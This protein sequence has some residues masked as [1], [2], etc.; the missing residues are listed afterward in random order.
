MLIA[1]TIIF[2]LLTLVIGGNRSAKGLITL[3]INS[4]FLLSVIFF[5]YKG[6]NPL[7]ISISACVFICLI[8]IFYQNGYNIKTKT[9]FIS[10]IIII[11]VLLPVIYFL[12]GLADI[13]GFTREQFEITDT[14][15]Y[16]RNIDVNM[17]LLQISVVIMLATGTII[18]TAMA[19]SS[20][21]HQVYENNPHL[22]KQQLFISGLNIGKDILGTTIQTIFFI[23]VA[24]YMNLL[25]Q[26][27]DG[28]SIS[29]IINSKAFVQE[30]VNI[31]S[32]CIGCTAIIPLT[33]LIASFSFVNL[34]SDICRQS[35][36]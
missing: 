36:D 33:A 35:T 26:F 27:M 22:S 14:N 21:L 11:A 9:A 18:D 28:Y 5:V 25:I 3:S 20:A 13:Q 24:E 12:G 16:S 17:T 23:F 15:G 32:A 6:F 34:K 8:A 29:K 10:V 1:L 31:L 2:I 30:T 4:L 7:L 19:I